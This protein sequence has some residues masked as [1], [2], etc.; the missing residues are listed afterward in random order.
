MKLIT[1]EI[2][3][4]FAEIG[5]Q[6]N[7]HDPIV[8]TKFFVPWGAATWLATEY[9]VEK[10]ICFGYVKGLV[11]GE[12]N[13]EWG[14]FSIDELESI[15]GPMGLKIERDLYFSEGRFSDVLEKAYCERHFPK[16]YTKRL[17]REK[18]AEK[19]ARLEQRLTE[20]KKLGQHQNRDQ[21]LDR[22]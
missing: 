5:E 17:E 3:T 11:Q 1:E 10:N 7:D 4:R 9:D 8:V 19:R 14:S 12:W 13:D 21:G 22:A 16:L 20:M 18:E 2:K 15:E 6:S